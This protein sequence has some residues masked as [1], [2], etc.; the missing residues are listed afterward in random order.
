MNKTLPK[1]LAALLILVVAGCSS[2]DERLAQMAMES[3]ERQAEQNREMSQLNREVAEGTKRIS[4]AIAESRQEM[5]AMETDLQVQRTRLEEERR[6]LANE[7]Y[8]ES[9]LVP[10]LDN[11]GVLMIVCLPLVITCLL[12]F[13]LRKQ[14]D[15]DAAVCDLLIQEITADQPRLLAPPATDRRAIEHEAAQ[16]KDD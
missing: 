4:E 1:I 6:S 11:L 2:S 5:L 10:I 16:P 13:N 15:D 8:R 14:T 3:T 12:L 9:L 7:R